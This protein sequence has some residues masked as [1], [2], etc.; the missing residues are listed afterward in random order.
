MPR[1]RI[2]SGC[3]HLETAGDGPV[4]IVF[5]HGFCQSSLFWRPTLGLLPDRYRGYAVDLMGF[6]DSD[7]P[8]RLYSIPG[9]A[10]D[11]L[12][13]ADSLGLDR[14]VLAGNSMGGVVCQSFVTQHADRLLKL[15]LV[16]TGP[17]VRNPDSALEKADRM[18]RTALGP[19]FFEAAVNGFFARPPETTGAMVEAAMKASR[20]A[21]VESTRSSA[22][23]NLVDRLPAVTVPTLIVQGAE[24]A[25]RTPEDGRLIRDAIP[26]SVLHVLP[27]AGHTPM[28]ERPDAFHEILF[29][30]LAE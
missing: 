21:M 30:F 16:S 29:N 24:D 23:L 11:V 13:L 27:G 26:G 28:L 1:A 6:G 9:F 4:P 3:L 15:V 25:G 2:S 10:D 8:D 7:K 22:S 14:F 17:F 18:A 20:R 12:E 5:L 19:D